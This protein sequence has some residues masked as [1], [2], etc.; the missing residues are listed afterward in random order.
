M[1]ENTFSIFQSASDLPPEKRSKIGLEH[2]I[3]WVKGGVDGQTEAHRRTD[4]RQAAGSRGPAGQRDVPGG[5]VA[6]AWYQRCNVVQMAQGV[7]GSWCRSGQTAEGIGTG[8]QP[9]AEGRIGPVD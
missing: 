2:F 1:F 3:L 4:S 5:D 9:L 6:T 8:E 7:R